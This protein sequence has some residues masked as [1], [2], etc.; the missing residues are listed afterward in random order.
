MRGRLRGFGMSLPAPYYEDGSVTIYHGDCR[1]IA[2][3]LPEGLAV[4]SD[5]PYGMKWDGK[6]TRGNSH[7]KKGAKPLHFGKTIAGDAEPFDPCP[8]IWYDEAILFGCNHF[9]Q[10]LP[11]GTMLVWIKRSDKG[12]GSF[13]SDAEVAWMKGG[14]GV[15]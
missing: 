9:S 7:G 4:V 12:F 6:V 3:D 5:P 2:P 10:R 1:E 13:L 8:W 15:Y 11:V 14:H